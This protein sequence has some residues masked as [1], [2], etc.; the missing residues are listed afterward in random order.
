MAKDF[1][2]KPSTDTTTVSVSLSCTSGA[3]TPASANA[4]EATPA[5][6]TVTGYTGDPTC[7]ATETP[8]PTGYTGS[9]S[10]AG[11][12]QAALVA[13]GTCTITNQLAITELSPA[14][15][16]VGLRNSDDQGTRF[17]LKIEL[18]QNNVLVASGLE[19]CVNGVTRNPSFATEAIVSWNTLSPVAVS[20]GDVLAFK[21]WTRIG[22]NA[23]LT[24]TKCVPGPGGSHNNATGL[25]LYYDSTSRQSRFDMTLG[26]PSADQYLHSNGNVCMNAP[27]ANVTMR[28]FDETAPIATSAKCKDSTSIN[29]AGGNLWKEIGTWSRTL[30]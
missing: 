20:P 25:R 8:V 12:C 27:S 24:E 28:Y 26:G 21:V 1:S 13:G 18:Y 7:T 2:D 19:R 6:F 30:P 4:S 29:F 11:T 9:G 14:H 23:D 10:P 16:W 15:L 22:T 5:S 3:A 17:D